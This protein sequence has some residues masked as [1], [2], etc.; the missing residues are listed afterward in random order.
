VIKNKLE[1]DTLV[2]I[3]GR[4]NIYGTQYRDYLDSFAYETKKEALLALIERED[5]YIK[6][7]F[8]QVRI[9]YRCIFDARIALTKN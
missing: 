6:R 4:E 8:D 7:A 3:L 9:S 5:M 2:W 1:R